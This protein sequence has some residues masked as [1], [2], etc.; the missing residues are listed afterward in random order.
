MFRNLFIIFALGILVSCGKNET[1]I[2]REYNLENLTKSVDF[3]FLNPTKEGELISSID[4]MKVKDDFF[5]ILSRKNQFLLQI[6]DIRS[7]LLFSSSKVYDSL[8]RQIFVNDFDIYRNELYVLDSKKQLISVFDAK[9][10]FSLLRRIKLN[11]Y[12]QRIAITVNGIFVYKNSQ[13]VNFEN[14]KFFYNILLLDNKGNLSN[15]YEPFDIP[16]GSRSITSNTNPFFVFDNNLYYIKPFNDTIFEITDTGIGSFYVMSNNKTRYTVENLNK[17]ET[18]DDN[19][20]TSPLL[21]IRNDEMFG[22]W[23]SNGSS[24]SIELFDLQS[25]KKSINI[26]GLIS[27]KYGR[28]PY[29]VTGENDYFYSIIDDNAIS[30]FGLFDSLD[31]NLIKRIDENGEVLLIKYKFK[32]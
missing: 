12:A 21:F 1:T 20:V 22:Y 25:R 30:N 17:G 2:L 18:I 6:F 23:Y 32:N 3:L 19:Q 9:N 13:A 15:G 10:K 26:N 31:K 16:E 11:F 27:K 8:E 29:P 5:Y 7:T 28:I 4:K 24:M 14:K